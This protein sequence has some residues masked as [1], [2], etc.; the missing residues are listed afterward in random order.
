MSIPS[1]ITGC[2][3]CQHIQYMGT[4]GLARCNHPDHVP[5]YAVSARMDTGHCGPDRRSFVAFAGKV[6]ASHSIPKIGG[7]K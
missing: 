6:L 5:T 1:E 2:G 7:Q 3:L 4:M